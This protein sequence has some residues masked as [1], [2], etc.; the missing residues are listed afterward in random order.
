MLH[1]PS[2]DL[3]IGYEC[4][5]FRRVTQFN[6]LNIKRL[7]QH[8]G[9]GSPRHRRCSAPAHKTKPPAQMYRGFKIKTC[10]LNA[11]DWHVFDARGLWGGSKQPDSYLAKK[12]RTLPVTCLAHIKQNPRHKCTGGLN[13]KP[14]SVLLSHGESPTLSSALSVF[15]SEFE[16]DSGGSHS[17]WPPGKLVN[18]GS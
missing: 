11:E 15:T 16:M 6:R 14:G 5:V 8:S 4:E 17:L 18:S 12:S 10:R 3:S 9:I 7:I 1:T 2:V 13:I